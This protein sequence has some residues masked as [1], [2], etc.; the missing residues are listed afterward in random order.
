[1][2]IPVIPIKDSIATR[3]LRVVFISYTV[4]AVLVT[5]VHMITEY[6]HTHYT[7]HQ[8]LCSYKNIF[9]PGL[10]GVI[11]NFD[12]EQLDHIVQG[13]L[14]VPIIV[15]VQ[16]RD[17]QTSTIL[18]SAGKVIANKHNLPDTAIK[19]SA[20][21]SLSPIFS[22]HFTIKYNYQ[23]KD[24]LV[25][26]ATIYSSRDVVFR[27][28]QLGFVFLI[29]N[30]I[31]KT[32]ILWLIFLWVSRR[33]LIRP[34]TSLTSQ[35]AQINLENLKTNNIYLETKKNDELRLLTDS[36]NRMIQDLDIA[37]KQRQLAE[38]NAHISNEANR[39]KTQFL[40]NMSHE[41]RTPLNSILGHAQILEQSPQLTADHRRQVQRM[42]H[43]GQYLLTLI[44]DILDLAKVEAGRIELYPEKLVLE[45]FFQELEY[46]FRSRT[47]KQGI[48]FKYTIDP[49][50]PA[51]IEIDPKRLRQVI[52]N[53]LGNAIKFTKHGFISLYAGFSNGYLLIVV[54]DSGPGIAPDQQAS[55]FRPFVQTG[56]NSYK[57]QGTG[58]GLAITKKIIELMGGSID[59]ESTLGKGS[60][61]K[62]RIPIK[63]TF[64]A[65][66]IE[67]TDT[68]QKMKIIGYQQI[69]DN[70]QPKKIRILIVDDILD[71]RVIIQQ[72]LQPIGFEVQT[73]DSGEACLQLVSNWRPNLIL[74][75]VR[76]PGLNGLETTK[77]LHLLPELNKLPIITVSANAY[78]EDREHSYAAGCV[79]HLTKPI[80]RT[81][82]LAALK[83]H[84]SLT[85][86]YAENRKIPPPIS[87]TN[88]ENV[89]FEDIH[90]K[91][92]LQM[93]KEGAMFKVIQYLEQITQKTD[94]PAQAHDLLILAQD[95]KLA[96][97][98]RQ[99]EK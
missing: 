89:Q 12:S 68:Q 40:A 84:L 23:N 25:G 76:M 67:Q 26:V 13:M 45:P 3:L 55:I 61:F 77:K 90:R 92:L 10:A 64:T 66:D 99:L 70:Q 93:V 73:V 57:A 80:D 28:V 49:S 42:Y 69:T 72:M 8:E 38:K 56:D 46:T 81:V 65:T 22:C 7:V 16:I 1:M 79:D 86:K 24:I 19:S 60:N 34:L 47:D 75:D 30:A 87:P 78:P 14:T 5:L 63:V 96:D 58:L 83:K 52:I 41:L 95:F 62:I 6:N 50:L 20:M 4:I 94:C 91:T 59:L 11:W 32:V 15:G 36:F 21:N 51:G 43:G 33:L 53:L 71:N 88:S 97:I 31:I 98:R 48:I 9:G 18:K 39:I 2:S 85:W 74:M 27:R 35:V 37:I 29:V 17:T 44:N 82:L 54:T